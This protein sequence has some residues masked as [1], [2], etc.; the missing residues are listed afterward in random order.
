MQTENKE[1]VKRGEIYLH[2]FG[3]NAGSIQNG[4]RPVLVVQCD[5]GNQASMTTVVAAL[6]SVIKKRYLPS[7]IILG[8]KFGLKEP[9]MVMLE[10][11]KTVNQSELVE[12]IGFVDNE[13]LLRKV[14]HG[15]KKALGL[16]VDK[17]QKH[18]GDIRK[19]RIILSGG[20]IRWLPKGRNAISATIW[21]GIISFMKGVLPPGTRRYRLMNDNKKAKQSKYE[22]PLWHKT[23]LSID[24]AVA[25]TG[26]GRAKLY[27]MTNREDCPFVLWIGNRRVIKRQVFDE[28]IANMYSI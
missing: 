16:W 4:V 20:L 3:N 15:L 5:E 25:Y 12:Y 23:N 24:E 18:K 14:N 17:P 22:V 6:T 11:L 21:A 8:D 27:E 26:I 7:H 28:Y 9:S 13:Y 1:K 19:H 10:Q 2:D